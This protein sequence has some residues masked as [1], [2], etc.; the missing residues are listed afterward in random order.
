MIRV[1]YQ[2]GACFAAVLL[3]LSWSGAAEPPPDYPKLKSEW[4]RTVK[5]KMAAEMSRLDRDAEGFKQEI[6]DAKAA[7]KKATDFGRKADANAA[8]ER[9]DRATADLTRLA[10][11]R[12][13]R[14]KRPYAIR[15]REL[16]F[17]AFGLLGTNGSQDEPP[18]FRV[19][20]VID[21]ANALMTW[22]EATYWVEAN[23]A[24]WV[25]GTRVEMNGFVHCVGKKE[26]KSAAGVK[27]TVLHLKS[28]RDED[29]K[30]P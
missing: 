14:Q 19:L 1:P 3:L 29:V 10:V 22:G 24:K 25:D 5:A 15:P 17:G 7:K 30:A 8:Q 23:T 18:V 27:R 26:Y 28:V 13:S 2:A 12:E 16:D 21:P 11:A 9:I 6:A 20:Q 4:D